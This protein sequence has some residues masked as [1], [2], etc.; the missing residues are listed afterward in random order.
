ML[1]REGKIRLIGEPRKVT[2]EYLY[3]NMSDEEKR[4]F[5]DEKKIKD[6]AKKVIETKKQRDE[7]YIPDGSGEEM[8]RKRII[9]KQIAEVIGVELSDDNNEPKNVFQ[10]GKIIN[11]D[12][13][14]KIY[15]KMEDPIFGII[16][17]D[18]RGINTLI[19]NTDYKQIKTG[20]FEPGKIS[21]RFSIE[22]YFADGQ[23]RISPAV[24]S[25]GASIFYDWKDNYKTFIVVGDY[26]SGGVADLKHTVEIKKMC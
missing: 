4:M 16:I 2:T 19:T 20:K 26:V 6:E 23:Y 9:K 24:A 7:I 15:K 3:Q 5:E 22:N 1:L 14:Y 21:V 25:K 12:V 17:S 10:T 13:I 11:V 8:E 18:L